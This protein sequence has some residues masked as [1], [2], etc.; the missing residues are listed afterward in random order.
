MTA[1]MK[2]L[3]SIILCLSFIL[4]VN[5]NCF[6]QDSP[7]KEQRGLHTMYAEAFGNAFLGMYSI[8][9]DYTL[10]LQE[11]HKL[12][13]KCGFGYLPEFDKENNKFKFN[14]FNLPITPEIS[15]LYGTKHHLELGVGVTYKSNFAT[16]RGGFYSSSFDW[17][18]PFR[19]GYRFQKDNGGLFLKAAA[20]PLI[21]FMNHQDT[22]DSEPEL[23][24]EFIP[25]GGAAIGYTFK[26]R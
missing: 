23:W 12:S 16:Y 15:Y 19:I 7:N 17:F 6:A 26:S 20:T 8:G 9:Y 10:K 13:F 4:S 2:K 24:K 1:T 18:L 14:V 11:K 3:L 25:W 21:W 22:E 5:N